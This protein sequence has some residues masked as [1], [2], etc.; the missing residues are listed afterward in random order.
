MR[1]LSSLAAAALALA[2]CEPPPAP[3]RSS[4]TTTLSADGSPPP[5]A[6][7]VTEVIGESPAP[8]PPVVPATPPPPAPTAPTAGPKLCGCALCDPIVSDDRCDAD[9]DCAP[10]TACHAP[11]CVAKAKA[12]PRGAG[13]V[14]TEVMMCGTADANVCGCVKGKCTLHPK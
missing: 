13:M 11:A 6:V 2:A 14:C 9:A 12:P 1:A 4:P 8:P 7:T 3:P 5:A 10:S